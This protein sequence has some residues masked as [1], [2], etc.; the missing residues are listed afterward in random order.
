[1]EGPMNDAT[2][3]LQ[4]Q[5]AFPPLGRRCM[6]AAER[7]VA[8]AGGGPAAAPDAQR[9]MAKWLRRFVRR[10]AEPVRF[11][12]G[13]L[14]VTWWA[15][16]CMEAEMPAV[17]WPWL[18]WYWVGQVVE[19]GPAP[20]LPGDDWRGMA[21]YLANTANMVAR[22]ARSKN[23]VVLEARLAALQSQLDRWRA[24]ERDAREGMA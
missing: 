2:A 10:Q 11:M 9:R 4:R 15:A 3:R 17:Q 8:A 5:L 1:M 20:D 24:A 23:T 19:A 12:G 18:A 21:A 13:P 7:F 6:A 14:A 22:A 16:D